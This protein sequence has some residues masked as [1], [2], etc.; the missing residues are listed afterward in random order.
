[1]DNYNNIPEE[2]RKLSQW[3]LW[4]YE[5]IGAE[6][7]TKVPYNPKGFHANVNDPNTWA[8]FEEVFNIVSLAGYDGIGF[9]FSD[10]DPYSFIDLD[11]TK[12]DA[13]KVEKQ[14]NVYREFDS[15]S[16]ISPSGKGLHIIIKGKISQGRKRSGIEIYS[17][18]RYATMTGNVFNEK[19]IVEYQEKLTQL[20]EQ[21]GKGGTNIYLYK[22]DENEK[23]NDE[24]IIKQS[25]LAVNGEKFRTLLHGQWNV[26]YQSQSEADL[27]FI[28]IIAFYTQNRNQIARIFRNSP[29]GQRD[30]AQRTDY[31]TWMINK[32]FDNILPQIDIEGFK[33]E[34]DKK[35]VSPKSNKKIIYETKLTIPPGLMGEIAQFI[36]AAAPRPVP[37]VALAASIGLMA[38][39]CGRAYNVSNTGLNQYV[40]LL[41]Q[42]GS[43]KEASA[44][45]IDKLMNTIKLQVPGS[46]NFIGPSEIASGQ[47]LV[48]HLNKTSQCFVSLLGEFGLRL[49]AMSNQGANSAEISL[50]R[51]LLDLFN[52]SG[53]GQ[54][55]RSS[56]YADAEKNI[57]QTEWPSF[58]ILGEST[59]E[60]F[61]SALS[62][63]MIAEGLLPRFT[64]IEYMGPR[65]PLNPNHFKAQPAA[66]LIEKL[67]DL[68]A[69]CERMM[70]SKRVMDVLATPEAAK[71]F[72]D[73]N[74]FCDD[75]INGA[76]INEVVRQL[77]NRAHVKAL[78]MSALIAV[79]VNMIDPI[80]TPV[81]ANWALDLV[82]NDIKSLSHKFESGEI[83]NSSSEN[84]QISEIIRMIREFLNRPWEEISKYYDNKI[85]YDARII[86]YSYLSR[87]LLANVA[88]KSDKMGPT[89]ALKRALANLTES[90]KLRE[91]NKI[92]MV[93][94]FGT[95]QRAFVVSNLKI[96]D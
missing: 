13:V 1:M 47:A 8:S 82:Q 2:L 69:N 79:G 32:S 18:Q 10:N 45:G 14:M 73:F 30:K 88:F 38:G 92:D 71:I 22:G 52:K 84:K 85:I 31:V 61:Y 63:D 35:V 57:K 15:Y 72:E 81:H 33:I 3:C 36:Y 12:G 66:Q 23:F 78:K 77:W 91:F 58:S 43:G 11:D 67:S 59:P 27:A 89:S 95:S 41:A 56:I 46:S 53:H 17:S 26:L 90:D 28:N 21:M 55:F 42:T 25:L 80:I 16:E 96:L 9:I 48:K 20:W 70:H 62:E 29:L 24:E 60:R 54:M 39:I 40:L 6:K 50:R 7:P 37:E 65:P 44:S 93:A 87:R 5:D 94:K 68:A 75:K 34:I 74:K 19:P 64:L 4:K 49:Q 76:G 51:I 83:G 86:P